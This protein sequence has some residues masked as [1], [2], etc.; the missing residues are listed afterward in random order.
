MVSAKRRNLPQAP[1]KRAD[2]FWQTCRIL[3]VKH[4]SAFGH[5]EKHCLT[6]TFC[7]SVF[8][9]LFENIFCLSQ[10]KNVCRARVYLMARLTN[11][12]LEKQNFKCLP[13]SVCPFGRGFILLRVQRIRTSFVSPLLNLLQSAKI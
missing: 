2:I 11:I 6:S 9:K 13:N 10:A 5:R 4:A 7:L 3:L 8:L 1:A 12:V